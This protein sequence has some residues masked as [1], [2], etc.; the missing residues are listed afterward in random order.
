MRRDGWWARK[1]DNKR[2]AG[3]ARRLKRDNVVKIALKLRPTAG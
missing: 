3:T 1:S 2:G